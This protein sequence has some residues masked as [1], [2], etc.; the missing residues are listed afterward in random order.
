M[1]RN[2]FW[3]GSSLPKMNL[4]ARSLCSGRRISVVKPILAGI[5][6]FALVACNPP[7]PITP[8]GRFDDAVKKLAA[9]STDEERFYPLTT[10][11]MEAFALGKYAEARQ[12]ATELEAMTPKFAGNWNYGN[13]V[14]DFNL[15]LGRLAV[16]EGEIDKAKKHLL[17]A[18]RSPGSPQMDSFG[19]N[20]SLANDLL[21]KGEKQVVLE[22]FDLCRAFWKRGRGRLDLWAKEVEAGKTPDF[23]ANL[24]Y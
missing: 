16:K 7:M 1:A 11:A 20:M 8:E 22:Y 6:L 5:S 3:W 15:V 19:P 21:K 12:Y 2:S 14:Q 23:G 18:G 13:A 9:A 4:S 17:A 24:F 10:A